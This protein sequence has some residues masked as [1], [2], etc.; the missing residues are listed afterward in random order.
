MLA[1]LLARS[2]HLPAMPLAHRDLF[3]EDNQP[4][5]KIEDFYLRTIPHSRRAGV[6]QPVCLIAGVSYLDGHLDNFSRLSQKGSATNDHC[7]ATFGSV[8][9]ISS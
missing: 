7:A 3:S 9:I 6:W 2:I 4:L 8:N 1:R 5:I